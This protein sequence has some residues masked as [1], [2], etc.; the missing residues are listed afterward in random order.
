MRGYV[1]V[2]F[3]LQIDSNGAID[4]NNFIGANARAGGYI[5]VRVTDADV[6]GNV[7]DGVARALNRCLD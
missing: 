6:I 5:A 1:F 3:L 4:P 7:A 2:D